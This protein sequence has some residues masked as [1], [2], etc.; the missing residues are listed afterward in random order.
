MVEFEQKFFEKTANKWKDREFFQQKPGKFI[1][2]KRDQ[3]KEVIKRLQETE[4]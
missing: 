1:Y 4:K 2:M 3:D